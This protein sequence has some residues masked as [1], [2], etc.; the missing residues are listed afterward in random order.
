MKCSECGTDLQYI[1]CP[2]CGDE[3]PPH[4]KF[5]CNCGEPLPISLEENRD[6]DDFSNR[7]LCS[8]G[9]CIGVIGA[10]GRCK[11]CGKPYTGP[12]D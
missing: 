12:A 2:S 6:E 10:D 1:R 3:T 5:C 4:S 11:E 8:D 9:T 7:V